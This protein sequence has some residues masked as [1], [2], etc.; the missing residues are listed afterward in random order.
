MSCQTGGRVLKF[1][2]MSKRLRQN[3][4]T[5]EVCDVVRAAGWGEVLPCR[6]QE[7]RRLCSIASNVARQTAAQTELLRGGVLVYFL[8]NVC[9]SREAKPT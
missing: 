6:R 7:L 1:L 9:Y 5:G 8:L 2:T 3:R 4:T